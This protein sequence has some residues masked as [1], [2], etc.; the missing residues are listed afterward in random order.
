MNQ[1]LG[2]ERQKVI[3]QRE[4]RLR[5]RQGVLRFKFGRAF[6]CG[7][8]RDV[9]IA[10]LLLQIDRAHLTEKQR[11][12]R[13]TAML[14]VGWL[15]TSPCPKCLGLTRL[16][17]LYRTWWR[18]GIMLEDWE[19]VSSLDPERLWC[20]EVLQMARVIQ[21]RR[22]FV[23]AIEERFDPETGKLFY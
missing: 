6:R 5:L 22:D 1:V 15:G 3:R 2:D 21:Q 8:A 14:H 11:E 10:Q 18:E 17:D 19:R 7:L 13:L 23:L 16:Y 20:S 9:V 4:E 12:F